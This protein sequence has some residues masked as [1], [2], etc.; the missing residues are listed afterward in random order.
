VQPVDGLGHRLLGLVRQADAGA[1]EPR[2]VML[3]T[4]REYA[5]ER[6]DDTRVRGRRPPSPR[7]L[8]LGAWRDAPLTDNPPEG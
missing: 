3:E 1:G 2:L 7:R 8:H 5:A 6:L 4:I